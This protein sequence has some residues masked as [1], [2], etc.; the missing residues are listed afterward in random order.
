MELTLIPYFSHI[1]VIWTCV[2]CSFFPLQ[3]KH[4]QNTSHLVMELACEECCT[5]W[6]LAAHTL[7]APSFWDLDNLDILRHPGLNL[8]PSHHSLVVVS[9]HPLQ[10]QRDLHISPSWAFMG[11]PI[12]EY[13]RQ[14]IDSIQITVFDRQLNNW[15]RGPTFQDLQVKLHEMEVDTSKVELFVCTHTILSNT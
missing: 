6:A 15:M 8:P 2:T 10:T 12:T 14:S 7:V 13:P 4:L 3:L 5:P 1:A 11:L 9:H